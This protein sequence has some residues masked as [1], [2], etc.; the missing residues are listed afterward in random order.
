MQSLY[1]IGDSISVHYAPI[2]EQYLRGVFRCI[3][4]EGEQEALRNLDLPMGANAGVSTRVLD[5]VRGKRA[6]SGIDADILLLNCGLHDIRTD[7]VTGLRKTPLRSYVANLEA[8]VDEV[9][10]MKPRLVWVRTTP[11]DE[12]VHNKP[13]AE[14]HRFGADVITYNAAADAVMQQHG[15]PSIDLNTFTAN[16]DTGP[17]LYCDH[18]HFPMPIREKQAAFIAGSLMSTHSG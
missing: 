5:F 13:G 12:A 15:V 3:H 16:L 18:V 11:C 9:A 7:P 8:I 17:S 6:R 2:L 10:A 4:R 14:F 1:I